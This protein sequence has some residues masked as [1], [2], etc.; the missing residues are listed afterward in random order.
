MKELFVGGRTLP[1]VSRM[2]AFA[3]IMPRKKAADGPGVPA[4][5]YT[6]RADSYHAY[7]KTFRMPEQYAGAIRTK[8]IGELTDE[9][10]GFYKEMTEESVPGILAAV[11]KLKEQSRV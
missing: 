8:P 7:E 2:N 1:Q 6:H 4:G 9:Y 11:E 10:E 5:S 3:F